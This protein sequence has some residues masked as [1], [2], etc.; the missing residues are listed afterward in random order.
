MI[1]QIYLYICRVKQFKKNKMSYSK[2][3][4]KAITKTFSDVHIENN[5]SGSKDF[6][7]GRIVLK[8][9]TDSAHWSNRKAIIGITYKGASCLYAHFEIFDLGEGI[10]FR[11]DH[12]WNAGSGKRVRKDAVINI[13]LMLDKIISDFVFTAEIN[14]DDADQMIE[15]LTAT[16][17]AEIDFLKKFFECDFHT[18]KAA[19]EEKAVKYDDRIKEINIFRAKRMNRDQAFNRM[20]TTYMA[21]PHNKWIA[22]AQEIRILNNIIS[23]DRADISGHANIL[24]HNY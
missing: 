19:A 8:P 2:A 7:G 20:K 13:H 21:K 18:L 6:I 23:K 12:V 15:I 3:E 24:L 11:L 16:K 17:K 5:I 9:F 1:I 14:E 4:F 10:R 22:N